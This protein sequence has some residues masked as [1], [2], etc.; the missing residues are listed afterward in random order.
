M[1]RSEVNVGGVYVVRVSGHLCRV[2]IDRDRG[3]KPSTSYGRHDGSRARDFHDGWDATNLD[4]GRAIHVRSAA[5]LRRKTEPPRCRRC[6]NCA[7]LEKEK[8]EA[9]TALAAALTESPERATMVR[10]AWKKRVAE[11]PCTIENFTPTSLV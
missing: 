11:L 9:R 4:S 6:Q 10:D 3:S 5:R 8:S 2:R 1:K 7:T